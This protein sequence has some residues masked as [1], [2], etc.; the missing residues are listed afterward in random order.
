MRR[1]SSYLMGSKLP[2][3]LAVVAKLLSL[4][5]FKD[6]AAHDKLKNP[7]IREPI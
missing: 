7:L 3:A 1:D 6:K 5:E 2:S 4:P